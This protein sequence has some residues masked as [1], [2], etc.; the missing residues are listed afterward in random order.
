M[1]RPGVSHPDSMLQTSSVMLSEGN[2]QKYSDRTQQTL[3]GCQGRRSAASTSRSPTCTHTRRPGQLRAA[4]LAGEG[5]LAAVRSPHVKPAAEL[6]WHSKD[7]TLYHI[8]T[9]YM[10]SFRG[11]LRLPVRLSSATT[12][13]PSTVALRRADMCFVAMPSPTGSEQ[14]AHERPPNVPIRAD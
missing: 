11:Y 12:L 1:R 6:H 13:E 2:M 5:Q 3:S 7:G 8:A 4:W 9:V 10:T 14:L